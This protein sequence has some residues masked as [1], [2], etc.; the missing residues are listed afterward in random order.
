MR[1]NISVVV[2]TI[3]A[4][5]ILAACAAGDGA[6]VSSNSG[7]ATQTAAN[8]NRNAAAATPPSAAASPSVA[9]TPADGVRRITVADAKAAQDKGE[10]IIVDVR[11]EDSYAAGRIKGARSIPE[12]QISRRADE[13]PRDKMIVTYCA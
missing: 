10:A 8:A 11:S 5:A 1:K 12:D 3:C 7:A 4:G 13:L 9:A 6:S 2:L